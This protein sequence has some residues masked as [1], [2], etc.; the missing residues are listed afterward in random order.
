MLCND[1]AA[2]SRQVSVLFKIRTEFQSVA[3]CKN[4]AI[5]STKF[6]SIAGGCSGGVQF[7]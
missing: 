7:R 4:N 2:F 1:L 6:N 3:T 5:S